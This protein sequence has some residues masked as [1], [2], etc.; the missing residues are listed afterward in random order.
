MQTR[1]PF[2]AKFSNLSA[3]FTD[4]LVRKL[5][6]YYLDILGL[7]PPFIEK[8]QFH[9]RIPY[10]QGR[11]LEIKKFKLFW[12]FG[13]DCKRVAF[14]EFHEL[15]DLNLAI[16]WNDQ[17]LFNKD[18][19]AYND[20]LAGKIARFTRMDPFEQRQLPEDRIHVE[21]A[22]F[23]DF[24]KYMKSD[25]FQKEA[26][27]RYF[28]LKHPSQPPLQAQ[29]P[30][31]PK[32]NPFGNAKPVDTLLKQLELEKIIEKHAINATTFKLGITDSEIE[33]T[34]LFTGPKT[35]QASVSKEEQKEASPELENSKTTSEPETSKKKRTRLVLQK[36]NLAANKGSNTGKKASALGSLV[37]AAV[38]PGILYSTVAGNALK[39]KSSSPVSEIISP[40]ASV[41]PKVSSKE[42][43]EQK[44]PA[45]PERLAWGGAGIRSQPEEVKNVWKESKPTYDSRGTS[46]RQDEAKKND[47]K[48]DVKA[49]PE[50]DAKAPTQPET[51]PVSKTEA[52]PEVKPETKPE[53]ELEVSTANF[54]RSREFST[55]PD[56]KKEE[57]SGENRKVETESSDKRSDAPIKILTR[58]PEVPP[59]QPLNS[60]TIVPKSS[61]P[62]KERPKRRS[63]RTR[64][65]RKERK[66]RP[67]ESATKTETE[68]NTELEEEK[69]EK[70][71]KSEKKEATR[72][73][74]RGGRR[75]R[76]DTGRTNGHNKGGPEPVKGGEEA[77]K[78]KKETQ[79][80]K[81]ERKTDKREEKHNENGKAENKEAGEP[82]RGSHR[83]RGGGRGGGGRHSHRGRGGKSVTKA[84]A[85]QSESV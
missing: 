44:P 81:E 15:L 74:G 3:D 33:K 49:E 45:Q 48:S 17:G 35:E 59:P 54:R 6:H 13:R 55:S 16:M 12:D 38:S 73:R 32:P 83:R 19:F 65:D 57:A 79:T 70:S 75:F 80:Q 14:V 31:R 71:E 64:R 26:D 9:Y 50:A 77:K 18:I 10:H 61:D 56:L 30:A 34:G 47:F 4:H 84:E 43:Q 63:V 41:S 1:P 36:K 69:S 21:L 42:I 29:K 66:E 27:L 39:S 7:F 20:Y 2:I 53:A 46:L 23:P 37:P 78:A 76:K 25:D 85:P 67:T 40:R 82:R 68:K 5:F 52:N 72:R 8:N 62:E 11:G 51:K 28:E 60:A 58:G 22:S 24:Q